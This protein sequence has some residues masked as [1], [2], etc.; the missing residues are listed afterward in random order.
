M[1]Q[2][3]ELV[4]DAEFWA[5]LSHAT[6]FL[7]PFSDMIHQVEADRPALG[8][9]YA[10]LM[11]LDKHVRATVEKWQDEPDLVASCPMVLCTWERRLDNTG[12]SGVQALLQPTH[13]VAYMLDPLYAVC[14]STGPAGAA[15]CSDA[16]LPN[17]AEE[18]EAAARHLIR[19]LG[20]IQAAHEFDELT[21]SGYSG[22]LRGKVFACQRTASIAAQ[23][24][25]QTCDGVGQKRKRQ[26]EHVASL[27][28]R[29]GLW[30]KYASQQY[31]ALAKVVVRL[32]CLHATSAATERNWSL[33]GRVYTSARNALGLERAKKL[34]T[35]CFNDRAEVQDQ[36]DFALLLSVIEGECASEGAPQ[37]A[38]EMEAATSEE[39]SAE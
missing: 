24:A 2:V 19:R 36:N 14:E 4:L 33:W 34:I 31:P 30:K 39:R 16:Q 15:V 7:Q 32:L 25:A 20:G 35:F 18:Q 9:C 10:G 21:L 17:V 29:K 11:Q 26:P 27:Q 3:A 37:A 13:I 1:L 5:Q 6:A 28:M 38:V 22:A 23:A 12:D 8:R